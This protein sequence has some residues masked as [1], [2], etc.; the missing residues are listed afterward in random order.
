MNNIQNRLLSL[1]AYEVGFVL[2]RR[3][4]CS[5]CYYD[6]KAANEKYGDTCT[7][8]RKGYELGKTLRGGQKTV[9]DMRSGRIMLLRPKN[10]NLRNCI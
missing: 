6:C 5:W 4:R 7:S 9:D 3:V 2:L 1:A 10:K 8:Q